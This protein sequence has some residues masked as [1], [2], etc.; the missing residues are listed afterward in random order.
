MIHTITRFISFAFLLLNANS[1]FSQS[2]KIVVNDPK[3]KSDTLQYMISDMYNLSR[4]SE[5]NAV[6]IN[7][8]VEIILGDFQGTLEVIVPRYERRFYL[9]K[10]NHLFVKV[11]NDGRIS[12]GGKGG[13]N[14]Q[15]LNLI[16]FIDE[17]SISAPFQPKK[18]LLKIDSLMDENRLILNKYTNLH[19]PTKQFLYYQTNNLRY[20]GP[21]LYSYIYQN[22]RLKSPKPEG[23]DDHHWANA[24]DSISAAAKINL[25]EGL[26]S[27]IYRRFIYRYIKLK[28][29]EIRATNSH[30]STGGNLKRLYPTL[31][32]LQARKRINLASENELNEKVINR[33]LTGSVKEFAY[34]QLLSE[35]RY[36]KKDDA[37][38][39]FQNF[40]TQFP[41]SQYPSQIDSMIAGITAKDKRELINSISF[42]QPR[43][44]KTLQDLTNYYKGKTVIVDM[45]GTWC[46]PCLLEIEA[47]S[48]Q[49]KEHFRNKPVEFLFI[50][51]YDTKNEAKWRKLI[52]YHRME[53]THYM[54]DKDL[55]LSIFDRLKTDGFPA[56]FIIKKN[57]EIELSKAGS[58]MNREILIKQVQSDLDSI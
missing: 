23:F 26:S 40:K 30:L 49:I 28:S 19:H 3:A 38:S 1:V 35:L 57:G 53:G 43:K 13:E 9:A 36:S 11:E 14:N 48:S 24:L 33:Y 54:A 29:L 22:L 8:K 7:G 6:F 42:I 58:P 4:P 15:V 18:L 31:D 45:W 10:N 20:L 12:V 27:P 44:L 55:T 2:T 51:N 5:H 25:P 50:S 41:Q 21:E 47:N 52:A 34:I 32:S 46:G 16:D 39:I 56:Y 17:S 37:L